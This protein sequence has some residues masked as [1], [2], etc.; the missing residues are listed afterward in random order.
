MEINSKQDKVRMTPAGWNIQ[1][2]YSKGLRKRTK[3]KYKDGFQ[4][5]IKASLLSLR[6]GEFLRYLRPVACLWYLLYDLARSPKGTRVNWMLGT[7][8]LPHLFYLVI[9]SGPGDDRAHSY[10]VGSQGTIQATLISWQLFSAFTKVLLHRQCLSQ[11]CCLVSVHSEPLRVLV[12]CVILYC[13]F[14]LVL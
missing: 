13:I 10:W 12:T 4:V 8:K 2:E 14:L 6:N 3:V 5:I 1:R 7:C 11:C 9:I